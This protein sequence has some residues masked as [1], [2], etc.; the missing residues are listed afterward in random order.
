MSAEETGMSELRTWK[1]VR[2]LP[3]LPPC[4]TANTAQT[5]LIR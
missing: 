1:D 5:T 4:K 3:S 2:I